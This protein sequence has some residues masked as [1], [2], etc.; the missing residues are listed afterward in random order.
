M[1]ATEICDLVTT[2]LTDLGFGD[3]TSLGY[4]VIDRR[5]HRASVRFDFAGEPAIRLVDNRSLSFVDGTG[6]L[7]KIVRPDANQEIVKKAA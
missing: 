1:E 7:L 5:R 3:A 4:F 2:V 6:K